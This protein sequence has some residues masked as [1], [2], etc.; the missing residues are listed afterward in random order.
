[1]RAEELY[2]PFRHYPSDP[3]LW[4]WHVWG[5]PAKPDKPLLT[6]D[7]GEVCKSVVLNESTF[8]PSGHKMGKDWIAARLAL[9]WL[10]TRTPGRVVCTATTQRQLKEVLWGEIES[11]VQSARIPL[12]VKVD[13]LRVRKLLGPGRFAPRSEIIGVVTTSPEAIHGRHAGGEAELSFAELGDGFDLEG[14]LKAKRIRKDERL[15]RVLVIGDEASAIRDIFWPAFE[16]FGQRFLWLS[17]PTMATGR[18]ADGVKAGDGEQNREGGLTRKVICMDVEKSPNV[19]F[20]LEWDRR[21]LEGSPPVI[22]DGIATYE[23][24][25]R[26]KRDWSTRD[27]QIKI[28]GRLPEDGD[29]KLYPHLWLSFAREFGNLAARLP[30]SVWGRLAMGIDVAEGADLTV[31][32]IF[33]RFGVYRC[34]SKQTDDTDKIPG[35]TARL[36]KRYGIDWRD[37]LFDASPGKHHVDRMNASGM[38]VQCVRFGEK[39]TQLHRAEYRNIRT[40]LY[41]EGARLMEPT[42]LAK[43]LMDASNE[44]RSIEGWLD[45]LAKGREEPCPIPDGFVYYGIPGEVE[46][47]SE[48]E[49]EPVWMAMPSG[50][51]RCASM[52]REDLYVLPK[53]YDSE[54]MLYLP[55]KNPGRRS[56]GESVRE[57]LG[58]SPDVGDSASLG[59]MAFQLMLERLEMDGESLL[60]IPAVA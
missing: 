11:A 54:G 12:G 29:E 46:S 53:Q 38:D 17:Q 18:F 36:C 15:P 27:Q 35:W 39:P 25:L 42:V 6:P 30:R 21:G 13:N 7:Q 48:G 26:W 56:N 44:Y 45:A 8:V 1:M 20:G 31:W 59:C 33:G 24:Y 19:H 34:V 40:E 23:D 43:S 55:P 14:W 10:C 52:L 32:T 2:A 60:D 57:L 50:D 37:V 58:R 47:H 51:A 22:F 49:P 16:S 9:W 5:D 41:G 3:I 4:M 28:H